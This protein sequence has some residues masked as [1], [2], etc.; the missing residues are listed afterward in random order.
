MGCICCASPAQ[1]F[2]ARV[3]LEAACQQYNFI[4]KET[5]QDDGLGAFFGVRPRLV[6]IAY[7]MLG[8]VAEAE[9]LMQDVWM[10]WQSTDRKQVQDAPAYL[11]TIT[12]RLALNVV[13]SARL[14][15]EAYFGIRLPEPVDTSTDPGLGAQR[16]E[17]LEFAVLL[18]LERLPPAERAA[19]ILREAFDYAYD[20]LGEILRV[21]EANARQLVTRAR[22][23]V[24]EG[25]RR[26]RV[27]AVEQRR[28]LDRFI[29]AAQEGELFPLEVLFA[30]DV[31]SYS[32]GRV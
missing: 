19:Y 8:S 28:L 11:V 4:M 5:V 13:Q 22:K 20:E 17:A 9:D 29:A 21:S 18:L 6:G 12:T 31:V 3:W 16:G 14:R 1:V 30:S 26:R 7:R 24:A 23:H 2:T 27:D 25:R 10:R 32:D 15:R